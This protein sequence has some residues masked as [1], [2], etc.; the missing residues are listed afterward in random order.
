MSGIAF[1][2]YTLATLAFLVLTVLLLV[3]Y[4]GGR[5]GAWLIA[6]SAM[7]M[8]WAAILSF[9][10]ADREVAQAWLYLGE[11]A[12]ITVWMGFLGSAVR[13]AATDL[14]KR[15]ARG[16]VF[17][18]LIVM[19][20]TVA[21]SVMPDSPFHVFQFHSV[22]LLL[23]TVAA[24]VLIEQIYRNTESN[25]RWAIKY[26]CLG[27]IGIFAYDCY[28]FSYEILHYEFHPEL[29]E[30]R[31]AVNAIAVPLIA[32]AAARSKQWEVN[33]F[34]SR[35]VVF[36]STSLFA[37]G[38]FLIVMAIGGYYIQLYG[39]TWGAFAQIV[40]SFGAILA[41]LVLL[42]SGQT[43]ARLRVF[44]AK[45]FYAGKYDYRQEW[46]RLVDALSTAESGQQ[47][48][49]RVV[50]SMADLVD[51]TGGLLWVQDRTG[52]YRCRAHWNMP[53]IGE[54]EPADSS[55]IRFMRDNW[56]IDTGERARR[57]RNAAVPE[58][59]EW[60]TRLPNA[61]LVV[62]LR[63]GNDLPGFVVLARSRALRSLNWEDRDLLKAVGA[64]A[65]S[66]LAL[67]AALEHIEEA[68]QFEAFNRLSAY[69]V[70]DIK[71]LVAQLAL[72][73]AN[74]EKHKQNPAFLEDAIGT[75]QNAVDK[76]NRLLAQL[77]KGRFEASPA[78]PVSLPRL[79]AEAVDACSGR[80]PVPVFARGADTL[81]ITVVA[82]GLRL[83]RAMEYL[84]Q[85]AQEATDPGGY[86]R[87]DLSRQDASAVITIE[88]NGC[89]MDDEFVREQLFKPFKTTKGNAGMGIGAYEA[90]ELVRGLGGSIDVKSRPGAG[91]T[92]TVQIPLGAA[93]S[94]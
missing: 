59:P 82:D 22:L 14:I 40:M 79:L 7:N 76:M 8:A 52:G 31:G 3:S 58:A 87:V 41:A 2:S 42:L 64:H 37:I 75:V 46:Q 36:Y 9:D 84:I 77:G 24:I 74:A 4:R 38:G 72:V 16:A 28:I 92:F 68:H 23:L 83:R 57:D 88:D 6:A 43:R 15:F 71:N 61:W 86:V 19:G 39:G 89:G 30:A 91:T 26:L 60:L 47:L 32:I 66:Y 81:D 10:A 56:I 34:V 25:Q 78:A 29:W 33:I 94:R 11:V 50:R 67:L 5:P 35:Q 65:A 45:H 93:E 48:R 85:N 18:A 1:L 21:V 44:L 54:I 70:H 49:D 55:L 51:S 13:D 17:A 63:H 73:V 62:P 90:R 12:R 80:P 27:L 53:D 20:Y 69:V